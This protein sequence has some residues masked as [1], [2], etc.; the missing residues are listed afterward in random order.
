M[1]VHLLMHVH[2]FHTIC[3]RAY[4]RVCVSDRLMDETT[5]GVMVWYG[6]LPYITL[7]LFPVGNIIRKRALFLSWAPE[8]YGRL[9]S[10]ALKEQSFC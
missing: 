4:V 5:S 6:N 8:I 1:F 2:I 9:I 3:V 7:T 10:L